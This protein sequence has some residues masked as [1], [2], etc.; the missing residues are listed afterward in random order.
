MDTYIPARPWLMIQDEDWRRMR[1]I[2]ADYITE[3]Q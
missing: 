2:I 1:E 3:G